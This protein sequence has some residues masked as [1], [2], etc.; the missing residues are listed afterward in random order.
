MYV[1]MCMHVFFICIL[2]TG[3]NQLKKIRNIYYFF[4]CG[5]AGSISK[6]PSSLFMNI[7][8]ILDP[9]NHTRSCCLPHSVP[10][11]GLFGSNGGIIHMRFMNYTKCGTLNPCFA[12]LVC[13]LQ[14]DIKQKKP[15]NSVWLGEQL[16]YLFLCNIASSWIDMLNEL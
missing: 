4:N 7:K 12:F 16:K 1:I 6:I 10:G 13:Q 5:I 11:E 2:S 14:Q 3:V 15:E 8:E 9:M